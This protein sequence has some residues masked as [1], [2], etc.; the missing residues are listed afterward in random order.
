M[1]ESAQSSPV[2]TPFGKYLLDEEI[3]RGGMAR[4]YLARLRG[5]GGFEKKLVVK[6]VRPEL[7]RDPRFVEMFVEEAKT[8]VQMSHPNIVPVYELGVVDGVYFLAMEHVEGATLAEMLC[9]GGALDPAHAAYVGVQVC[10]ALEYAHAR[11]DLVHR[12]VTPRNVIVDGLGH[13][14]LLDFGIA[15]KADGTTTGEVFGS[16]GYMS[17]EQARCE[18]LGPKSDL[19]SLGAVLY[20]AVAGEPAFL[21]GDDDETRRALDAEPPSLR[22]RAPEPLAGIVDELLRR[23]PAARPESAA[24]VGQRLRGWLATSQPEGVAPDVAARADAARERRSRVPSCPPPPGGASDEPSHVV[25]SIATSVTLRALLGEDGTPEPGTV[26]IAGR[27]SAPPDED[28]GTVPIAGRRSA[29]PDEDPGTVPIAGRSSA[30]PDEDRTGP[31]DGGRTVPLARTGTAEPAPERPRGPR[32][33]LL[34]VVLLATAAAGAWAV[35]GAGR[36]R[37]PTEPVATEPPEVAREAEAE[38][39][40]AEVEQEAEAEAET[41]TQA[42]VGP[43]ADTPEVQAP[44]HA[45][46][47]VT[48]MPWSEVSLD[49]R[50]VGTTPIRALRLSPGA[51]V[52]ELHSPPLGR[53]AR[54]SFRAAAGQSL[55]A[56]ADLNA[57]PPVLTVR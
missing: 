8:L 1:H 36:T 53:S 21:R 31:D 35:S 47:R 28:P 44:R 29:P 26:P 32:A 3:A 41:E 9:E 55:Q 13:V 19:F 20:E 4:V 2:L 24:R 15:A 43:G 51:H 16:H 6:Q 23:D 56:H 34:V 46:V 37:A 52:L 38:V 50:A 17:P 14:R 11:F 54:A 45:S 57:D 7:A 49:G 27:S 5:L 40:P 42:A 33:L 48:S 25:R 30:P 10:E 39:E 12:D 18:A 22:G